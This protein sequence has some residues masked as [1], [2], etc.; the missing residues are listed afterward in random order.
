MH[1]AMINEKASSLKESKERPMGGPAGRKE[2]GGKNVI[3][4]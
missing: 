2:S 1:V 4:L 3:T